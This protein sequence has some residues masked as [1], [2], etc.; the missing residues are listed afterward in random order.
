MPLGQ[1]PLRGGSSISP[2]LRGT[3]D[4]A[5]PTGESGE[6]EADGAPRRRGLSRSVL[7]LFVLIFFISMFFVF[8]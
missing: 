3:R 2:G 4:L 8:I 1:R 6:T 5:G 7:G